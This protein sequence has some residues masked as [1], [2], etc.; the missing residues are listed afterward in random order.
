MA[1]LYYHYYFALGDVATRPTS[2]PLATVQ[3]LA[4][5][6]TLQRMRLALRIQIT[7]SDKRLINARS[8]VGT[9]QEALWAPVLN[10]IVG[11]PAA[12][13]ARGLA[14]NL[15]PRVVPPAAAR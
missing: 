15:P 12:L 5:L 11:P 4:K 2:L 8:R 1:E 13:E 14:P 10:Q 6:H 3:N 9:S 7:S